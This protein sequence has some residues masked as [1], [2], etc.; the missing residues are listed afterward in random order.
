MTIIGWRN[1]NWIVQNSWGE[2]YGLNGVVHIP[3]EY[4]IIEAWAIIDKDDDNQFGIFS[5]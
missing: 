4:P 2:F 5:K 1:N 3:F